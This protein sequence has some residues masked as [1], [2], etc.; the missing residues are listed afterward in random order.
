[1]HLLSP[2]FS[3]T[4]GAVLIF[5][6]DVLSNN[7]NITVEYLG[8]NETALLCIVPELS[9]E[10]EAKFLWPNGTSIENSASNQLYITRGKQ[11]IRLNSMTPS[12]VQS[13][14]YCCIV[15]SRVKN[16]APQCVHLYNR[17]D[18]LE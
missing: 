3:L 13:G 15:S 2:S 7:T 16:P 9:S 18:Y 11:I 4:L 14:N 1:M 12:A 10:V 8:N 17:R 5:R 6:G